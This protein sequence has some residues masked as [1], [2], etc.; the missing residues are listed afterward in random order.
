MQTFFVH[1]KRDSVTLSADVTL[2]L[3]KYT[4]E[5]SKHSHRMYCKQYETAF[6]FLSDMYKKAV[7][8]L[9]YTLCKR[10]IKNRLHCAYILLNTL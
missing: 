1:R 10:A 4:W 8:Q 7:V 2:S 5:M 6:L 9:F 3:V